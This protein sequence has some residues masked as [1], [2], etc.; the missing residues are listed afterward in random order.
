MQKENDKESIKN[1]LFNMLNAMDSTI[2]IIVSKAAPVHV[3]IIFAA[4]D[5][6]KSSVLNISNG[7]LSA[8]EK[9][10]LGGIVIVAGIA[11]ALVLPETIIGFIASLII[12]YIIAWFL[13]DFYIKLREKS[14]EIWQDAKKLANDAL[15]SI[16]SL[17]ETNENSLEER[18]EYIT[19][20][21]SNEILHSTNKFMMTQKEYE[22]CISFLCGGHYFNDIEVGNMNFYAKSTPNPTYTP[23]TINQQRQGEVNFQIQILDND[24][25]API[26]NATVQLENINLGQKAL[27]DSKG[28][29]T[30]A[31][32]ES[33]YLKPFK[34]RLIHQNYQK[35]PIFDRDIIINSIRRREKPFVLRFDGKFSLYFNGKE[36]YINKGNKIIDYFNA[37]SG[38]VLNLQDKDELIKLYKCEN[39]ISS[40]DLQN[41]IYF[42]LDKAWQKQKDGTM[43]EK[44]VL[45]KSQ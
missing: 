41:T 4:K 40:K 19:E 24:T 27:T 38:K 11:T 39:F 29:A 43:P 10:A 1:R 7:K 6:F 9:I 18:E 32:K 33:E 31:I 13:N 45:Y 26:T 42:C 17:I 23:N 28:F 16:M 5:G 44:K 3:K 21:I 36:I 14:I 2:S 30:F 25:S 34:I 37:H 15:Q 22:E 8:F 20:K 35:C 12:S